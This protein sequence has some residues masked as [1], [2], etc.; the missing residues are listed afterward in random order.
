MSAALP[1]RSAPTFLLFC[2]SANVGSI[3]EKATVLAQP[4]ER[5]RLGNAWLKTHSAGAGPYQLT[6]WAA[7]DHITLDANPHS[8]SPVSASGS[9]SA[10]WPTPRAQLLMLQ[11]GDADIAR[12][13]T[14]DQLK[15]VRR[16]PAYKVVSAGQGSSIYMALNQNEPKLA[17][18]QVR[19]AIKWAIDYD[20]IAK[21]ITP[22]TYVVLAVLPAE[23]AP[24]RADG[25]AV[26]ARTW[27]RPRRCWR[28]PGC[29]TGSR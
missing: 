29:R 22:D 1:R 7:S 9:R 23:R 2:L 4:G 10:T 17:K 5:R 21:N 25:H 15:S 11:K 19:Q 6:Q 27:R 20:A 12:D 8:G 3:V 13:L 26:P 28:R 16:D 18:P 24:G 14:P